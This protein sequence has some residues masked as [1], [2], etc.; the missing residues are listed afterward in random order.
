M[1]R[2]FCCCSQLSC[3]WRARLEGSVLQ[4]QCE[5][6]ERWLGF[7]FFGVIVISTS[8]GQQPVWRVI[9]CCVIRGRGAALS[10]ILVSNRLLRDF[11]SKWGVGSTQVSKTKKW[12]F[13]RTKKIIILSIFF[14]IIIFF[15]F[16]KA[17]QFCHCRAFSFHPFQQVFGEQ[18]YKICVEPSNPQKVYFYIFV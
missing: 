17:A 4:R 15:V 16:Q 5:D 8:S 10:Q 7:G 11:I 1:I 3:E 13:L 9:S 14:I 6:R 2:L 12:H 18:L